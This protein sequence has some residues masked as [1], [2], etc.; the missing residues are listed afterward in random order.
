VLWGLLLLLLLLLLH[1]PEDW[2]VVSGGRRNTKLAHR[3]AECR[4]RGG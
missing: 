1:G 4:R 3:S 2:Q